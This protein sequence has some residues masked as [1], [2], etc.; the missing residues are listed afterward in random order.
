MIDRPRRA[1][2]SVL[3][4]E[5]GRTGPRLASDAPKCRHLLEVLDSG[6]T[7]RS[8]QTTSQERT[9]D[10]NR[11]GSYHK[12]R[13]PQEHRQSSLSP[14]GRRRALGTSSG[15]PRSVGCATGSIRSKRPR[16]ERTSSP[17]LTIRH[18]P[19]DPAPRRLSK[20]SRGRGVPP[21]TAE[22]IVANPLSRNS[23]TNPSDTPVE[24]IGPTCGTLVAMRNPGHVGASGRSSAWADS[25]YN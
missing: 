12:K 21:G 17:P 4:G 14:G 9:Q 18:E 24:P 25:L 15:T 5:G 22:W 20:S 8:V 11:S 1:S 3:R 23:D 13:N 6:E 19:T 2:A 16:A 10:E 7:R